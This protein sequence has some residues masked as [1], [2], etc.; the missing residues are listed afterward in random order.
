MTRE[1][2][3]EQAKTFFQDNFEYLYPSEYVPM[4]EIAALTKLLLATQAV[5]LEEVEKE[6]IR[7]RGNGSASDFGK[8]V[9]AACEDMLRWLR[10]QAAKLEAV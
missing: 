6:A 3:E 7:I 2:A 10:E 1:Q 8:G 9:L 5:C 4:D